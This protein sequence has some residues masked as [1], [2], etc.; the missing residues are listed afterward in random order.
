[1]CVCACARER[2]LLA[3]ECQCMNVLVCVCVR[4]CVCLPYGDL[5]LSLMKW[6]VSMLLDKR[7]L[8]KT[9]VNVFS[10]PLI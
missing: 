7:K 5:T 4:S 3:V 9:R 1:M 6:W 10:S 2:E 8:N